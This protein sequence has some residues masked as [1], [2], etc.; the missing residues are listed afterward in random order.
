MPHR[1]LEV[2]VT[3]V[4]RDDHLSDAVEDGV[5]IPTHSEPQPSLPQYA[6]LVANRRSGAI[7]VGCSPERPDL[8]RRVSVIQAGIAEN[9]QNDDVRYSSYQIIQL[10]SEKSYCME[11]EK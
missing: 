6:S 2:G 3:S 11:D 10:R 7:G 9:G 4:S 8:K 5:A 1:Q